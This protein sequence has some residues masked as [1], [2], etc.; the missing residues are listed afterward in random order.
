MVLASSTA[1][2]WSQ[3]VAFPKWVPPGVLS[4]GRIA[5]TPA[6][7][8]A[9]W[10]AWSFPPRMAGGTRFPRSA[11]RMSDPAC[12]GR[13][14]MPRGESRDGHTYKP[15][16]V[17]SFAVMFD[18]DIGY[19]YYPNIPGYRRASSWLIARRE[20]STRGSAKLDQRLWTVRYQKCDMARP[21]V[22]SIFSPS[23]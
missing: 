19:G 22:W 12:A 18:F 2:T 4:Q 10:A 11:A 16:D 21:R 3:I 5:A 9:W 20:I 6:L 1:Q 23:R 15:R 17:A 14:W 13:R 8:L 7:K